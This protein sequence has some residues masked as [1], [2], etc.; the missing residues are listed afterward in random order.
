M[1]RGFC[2]SVKGLKK[3][4]DAEV[5]DTVSTVK[6]EIV[7]RGKQGQKT[8]ELMREIGGYHEEDVITMT[9]AEYEALTSGKNYLIPVEFLEGLK[10]VTTM[11]LD[12]LRNCEKESD[13]AEVK[14]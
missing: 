6:T 3:A 2:Q 7:Y 1:H 14:K 5:G 9:V 13:L 12:L 8:N 11:L 4:F 10:T